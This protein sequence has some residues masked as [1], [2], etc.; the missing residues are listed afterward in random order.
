MGAGM[1]VRRCRAGEHGKDDGY[2]HE[3]HRVGSTR[4]R[5]VRSTLSRHSAPHGAAAARAML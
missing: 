3:C 4:L 1:A 5:C 2:V